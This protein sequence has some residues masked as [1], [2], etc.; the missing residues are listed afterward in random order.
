MTTATATPNNKD[1]QGENEKRRNQFVALWAEAAARVLESARSK[2]EVY[3]EGLFGAGGTT[4]DSE[5]GQ[6]ARKADGTRADGDA[7]CL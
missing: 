1:D 3:A 6:N 5:E 4:S 7:E 2:A